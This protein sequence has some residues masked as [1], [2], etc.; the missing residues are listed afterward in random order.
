[1]TKITLAD[2]GSLI[3][4]TTAKTVI[5]NNSA[6]IETAFD[7]NLSRDGTAPNQM[8]SQLDMNSH[9][10]INLPNG[11]GNQEPVTVGTF[12]Q[13]VQDLEAQI[14]LGNV[15]AG[16]GTGQVLTKDTPVDYAYSWHTPSGGGSGTV[17]SVGLA[18][19][20]DFT[21]T[22]SPVTT[23]G[24]LTGSYVT[25]PTGTGALVRATSPTLVTPALGTPASGV[26]TNATGL[27]LTTG[28]T[29]NLPV[30]NL[31]SGT[32]ASSSTFW[33]G[34]ATWASPAGGGNVT[35]PGSATANG[36]AVY[37][38]TTGTIIKDHAATVA[39]G[40]EV[41]GLGTGVATFLGT[42]SSANLATAVTDE[43]GSGALVFATSPAL[44]TPALGTPAS[45]TLTNT[46]GFPTANLSGLGTGVAAWL[47]A[48]TSANLRAALPDETGS[49]ALV[50]NTSC[51]LALPAL[52]TPA[53]GVLTNCTGT[54]AGLT[55]GNVTTNANL[56]GPITSTGNATAVTTNAITN[57]M[58][59]QM[60]TVTIKGNNTGGTA[61]ALDLTPAQVSVMLA[62][63][64]V[65]PISGGS[66]TYTTPTGAKYLVVEMMGG[67]GGGGSSGT[68]S[69]AATAGTSSTFGASLTAQGGSQGTTATT[70]S[71][72]AGGAGGGQIGGDYQIIGGPGAP[73]FATGNVIGVPGGNGAYG[74]A[75]QGGTNG[76][77]NVA[78]TNAVANTGGGGG[79]AG[80]TAGTSTGSGGGAGGF[81]RKLIT[82]PLATYAYAIGAGGAGGAAGTGGAVGGNGGTGLIIV[83]AYFQ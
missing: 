20:A 24:T 18:L 6:I 49:G 26:L 32:S 45:G 51:S 10:I 77:S 66:G 59:A 3:E 9:Q 62:A 35:G 83:T 53:S 48:P 50:F 47:A 1:M 72:S 22:N 73:A 17:T 63:P 13:T 12:N 28:V 31:N 11:V 41:S 67:G 21:V 74:G 81:L 16:G 61:N 46:T 27:P 37:N 7:N 33:R 54:A 39:I 64:Q 58:L 25:P 29:G 34:D 43:T 30:A 15:P 82:S 52:G 4:A 71:G 69:G 57:T 79:G 76:S 5:N 40:S 23:T 19:P 14:G 68:S 78:G 60:P 38:G 70:S 55:A 42:P 75:G 56:T 44:V 8:L 65:T 36:F 2:V 80:A